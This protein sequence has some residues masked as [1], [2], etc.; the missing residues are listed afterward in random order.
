MGVL[1]AVVLS[2]LATVLLGAHAHGATREYQLKAVF[3]LNFSRFV[4][5]PAQDV[6]SADQPFAICIFGEDPFGDDIDAVMRDEKA[7]GQSIVVRRIAA[8]SE[9]GECRILFIHR[10]A[11]KDIGSILEGLEGR[12]VLTVSDA[13]GAAERGV[14]IGLITQDNRVRLNVNVEVART[15]GLTISSNLLR[16]AQI[17]ATTREASLR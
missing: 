6:A 14:M 13:D 5:W 3:L 16:S 1:R 11:E 8:A 10:S 15:A 12:N 9:A 17:V 7:G 2:A 4:E